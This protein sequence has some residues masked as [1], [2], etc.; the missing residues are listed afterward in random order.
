VTARQT[1]ARPFPGALRVAR[2]EFRSYL[3]TPWPY[4]VAAAFLVLT[5]VLFYLVSD[6]TREASLRFWFP[7]LAFVLLVTVPVMTSRLIADEWRSRHLDVVLGRGVSSGGLILG[8]WLATVGF[9]VVLMLPTLCYIGFLA[10]WGTPD[11]P[12]MVSGYAG[13]VCLIALFCAVGTLA[14]TLTPTAV[15]AG[16]ASFAVLVAAQLVGTMGSLHGLSFQPH[17]DDFYRGAPQLTDVLYFLS[18]SAVCLILA[19]AAQVGRLR[20]TDRLRALLPS[21]VALAVALGVNLIPVPADARVDLT[22]TSRFTLSHASGEVLKAVT[23]PVRITVFE[24]GGSAEAR[25]A[26]VLLRQFAVR[27]GQISWR[28]IDIRNTPGEAERLG[29]TDDGDVV[30]EARGHREVFSPLTEESVTSAI[31]RLSRG[32]PS[33]VCAL[34]G[35]GERELDD[36][37]PGGY[38]LARQAMK[39]NGITAMRLDLT[40]ATSV[41]AECT[42]LLMPGPT[43][44]LSKHEITLIN[45]Y[46]AAN[47]R[48]MILDDPGGPDVSAITAPYGLRLLPGVVV[49]PNRGVAGD[50]TTL[51]VNDFPSVSPVVAKVSGVQMVGSGGITT[52]ASERSGLSVAQLAESSAKSWLE[53]DSTKM[54]FEPERGDR[55]GPV[56]L[57]ATADASTVRPTGET[58]VSGNGPS[59]ARTRMVLVADADWACNALLTEQDNRRLFI[60]ALNWLAGQEDL[61]VVGGERPDLRRLQITQGDRTLLGA[62]SMAGIPGL[63]A[64]GGLGCWARRRRR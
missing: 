54:K 8:K 58:R 63:V 55:A 11:Y 20:L 64:L 57:A 28:V 1:L 59:I 2:R 19:V 15:A 5:G 9:F 31:T 35:H 24:P 17:L 39:D 4:G 51:L 44:G 14:S 38:E 36:A 13:A 25:D 43:G 12:P 56:V 41:P 46:L 34:A 49:D 29:A 23:V 62:V 60:N 61:V 3:S 52:A 16:L 26:K 22:S 45:S 27:N 18:T 40:V 37:A 7:N 33:E 53:T 10:R 32:A 48:M 6:G 47:G 50:P 30:V 42:T 21:A